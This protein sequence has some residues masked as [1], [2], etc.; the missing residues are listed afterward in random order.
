MTDAPYDV[1]GLRPKL[2]LLDRSLLERIVSE[3]MDVLNR[4]GVYIEDDEALSLL[5]D[6]G[7]AVDPAS[8][9][10]RIPAGLVESCLATA[11]PCV[12]LFDREGQPALRLT[13]MNV[14]FDPGSAALKILDPE[15]GEARRP[16]T[17]DLV[18]MARLCEALPHFDAQSTSMVPADVPQ[19]MADRYRLYLSLL[20]CRKPVITGTFTLEAFPVMKEMLAAAA[21][22]EDELRRRPLAVFDA[23]SSQ[24]LKWSRLTVR[25][26]VDCARSGIP[27][28]LI[29]VPMLGATAPVT[30]AGA[31]VQHTA[32]NLSGVVIHQLAGRGSPVIY[33]GSPAAVDM[34]YGTMAMGSVETAMLVAGYAQI[35]RRLNLPTHGYTALS[36]SK[37]LDAQ[38][39][40][41]TGIGAVIAAL[42]GVNV[43]SGAGMLEFE[44]CQSLE[45][46][47]IDNEACGMARRLIGGIVPGTGRLAGELL[48]DLNDGELFLT[49]PETL[50]RMRH[51]VF[52]PGTVI[53]RRTREAW[54]SDGRRDARESARRRVR[55]ILA[56]GEPAPPGKDLAKELERIMLR[57]ASKHGLSRLPEGSGS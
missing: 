57:E 16:V 33:G 14:H 50:R 9:T 27:A 15:T 29:S 54:E 30:L 3:A 26:L 13:G 11:P 49:S 37:V 18:S 4:V 7:A 36:D 53:D 22:G 43:V 5:G 40:L 32:E 48:G 35:G 52:V 21:G 19:E 6:S 47:V 44:N 38:A 17:A 1:A 56:G 20:H 45:K 24:P 12:T 28:E 42:A 34:R 55:E 2:E 41:E 31:L 39:G 25:A 10:A 51:E 23:C 46:L 8:S